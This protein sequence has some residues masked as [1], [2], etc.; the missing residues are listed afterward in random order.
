MAG[1]EGVGDAHGFGVGVA[2]PGGA[3]DGIDDSAVRYAP[4]VIFLALAEH[5]AEAVFEGREFRS[6]ECG[7]GGVGDRKVVGHADVG[8]QIFGRRDSHR[9]F[10]PRLHAL[11][12]EPHQQSTLGQGMR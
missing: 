2:F 11:R 3:F 7:F 5:C 9:Q 8:H 10:G 6:R 12:T 4:G 1:V